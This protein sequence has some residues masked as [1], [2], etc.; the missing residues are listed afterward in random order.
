AVQ[1]AAAL[2]AA[3]DKGIV[4][5]DLKPA[6]IVISRDGRVKVLDFGLAKLASADD[7]GPSFNAANSPTIAASMV[8]TI[9]GT[10]AYMSPE[11]A[12]AKVADKRAD[13]WAFGCVVFEMLAGAPAFT[14]ETI[15][16]IVAAVVTH[17]PDWSALP[18]NVPSTVRS[19]LRRCL[20]K[21]PGDRLHDAAD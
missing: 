2:E 17:E 8:G 7:S 18:A 5:R 12:R 14:G 13:I 15:T 20:R 1:V 10:A 16:D 21:D 4:H 19:A 6:N 9:L 3:H 11:P